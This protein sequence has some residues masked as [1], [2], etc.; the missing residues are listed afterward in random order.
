MKFLPVAILL[1]SLTPA[2]AS[3]AVVPID[4]PAPVIGGF[5]DI[6]GIR[7]PIN[8]SWENPAKRPGDP[9][10]RGEFRGQTLYLVPAN[11]GP[12]NRVY[13]LDP[14]LPPRAPF[15]VIVRPP[16]HDDSKWVLLGATCSEGRVVGGIRVPSDMFSPLSNDGN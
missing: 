12:E 1:A 14:N 13:N 9:P 15:A 11:C 3:N 10:L 7:L 8:R 6:G 4:T 16:A 5:V 2:M